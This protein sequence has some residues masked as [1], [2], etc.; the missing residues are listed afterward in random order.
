MPTVLTRRKSAQP[1]EEFMAK[2]HHSRPRSKAPKTQGPASS[3]TRTAAGYLRGADL[4]S[5]AALRT[6]RAWTQPAARPAP[7]VSKKPRKTST[8]RTVTRSDTPSRTRQIDPRALFGGWELPTPIA[9]VKTALT[10]SNPLTNAIACAR[11]RIR[12]AV[13]FSLPV[14]QRGKGAT[15]PKLHYHN[16]RCK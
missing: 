13:L 15:S 11:S 1:Q 10:P 14:R 7:R 9:R 6:V 2:T 5:P 12:R 3:P 16:L 4:V 8:T